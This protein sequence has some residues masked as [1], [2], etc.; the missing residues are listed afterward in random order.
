MF[1]TLFSL[2]SPLEKKFYMWTHNIQ[3]ISPSSLFQIP[4][5]FHLL[6]QQ[7]RKICQRNHDIVKGHLTD[8][9]LIVTFV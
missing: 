1:L 9:Y 4:P 2:T 8:V 3:H 6:Q 5:T 7:I